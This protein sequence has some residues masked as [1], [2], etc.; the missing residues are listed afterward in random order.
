MSVH[1]HILLRHMPKNL[2]ANLSNLHFCNYF[3]FS[4]Y[5][6]YFLLESLLYNWQFSKSFSLDFGVIW[7]SNYFGMWNCEIHWW[8]RV[9]RYESAVLV[10]FG[11]ISD[12]KPPPASRTATINVGAGQYKSRSVAITT[13]PIIPPR[14][15]AT[16]DIA[17]PVAL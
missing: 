9:H 10:V 2:N 8:K 16:I 1:L 12:N 3:S 17:T 5:F 13:F 6:Y 14:R 11:S 7:Y 15:A 4:S